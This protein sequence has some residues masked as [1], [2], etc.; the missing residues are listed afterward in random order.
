M[1]FR[2]LICDGNKHYYQ[3]VINHR[4]KLWK[5]CTSQNSKI[6]LRSKQLWHFSTK[7]LFDEEDNETITDWECVKDCAWSKLKEVRISGFKTKL[8]SEE[9]WLK[10]RDKI[11]S[12]SGRQ[13]N[14]LGGKQVGLVQEE[15]LCSFLHA[16]AAGNR[17]PAQEKVVRMGESRRK[18][19]MGNRELKKQKGTRILFCTEGGGTDWREK[20]RKSRS[21]S[22]GQS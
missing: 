12:L 15:S 14:V 8:Q 10:K 21:K 16:P 22:C 3:P 11:L 1:T 9:P 4:P 6:L 5:V 18:H 17:E 7:K 2:I 20:F 19:A 13:E